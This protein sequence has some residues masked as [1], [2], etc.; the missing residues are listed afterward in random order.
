MTLV[1]HFGQVL[2]DV[3]CSIG[4]WLFLRWLEEVFEHLLHQLSVQI[5]LALKE[6][7]LIQ[8]D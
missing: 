1:M 5:S 3:L 7:T 2:A 6:W 4:L 8:T